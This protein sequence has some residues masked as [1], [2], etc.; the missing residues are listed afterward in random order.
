MTLMDWWRRGR[1]CWFTKM[2]PKET[3]PDAVAREAFRAGQRAAR[4]EDA[5]RKERRRDG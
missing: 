3:P 2:P 4:A 1:F 5:A